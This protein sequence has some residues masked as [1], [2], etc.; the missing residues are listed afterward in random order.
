MYNQSVRTNVNLEEDVHRFAVLYADANR[1]TLGAALSELVR[2]GQAAEASETKPP[3]F[4]RSSAGVPL[5]PDVG[6]K[7]TTEMVTRAEEDAID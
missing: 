3:V 5:F 4:E 6:R 7:I 2:K 1:I